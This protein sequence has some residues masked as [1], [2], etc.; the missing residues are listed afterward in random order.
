MK[1]FLS[2]LD[3]L[4]VELEFLSF[5]DVS[6][7]ATGLSGSGVDDGVESLLGELVGDFGVDDSIL[8]SVVYSGN[9]SLGFSLLDLYILGSLPGGEVDSVLV[10]IPLSEGSGVDL[11]DAV[12]DEGLGSDELVVGG[13]VD[14]V[15][16]SGF[17]GDSF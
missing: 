14:D 16:Y 1:S 17:T 10:G 2:G 13:I 9:G 8:L 7:G 15:D 11:D 5:E 4:G 6:V 3:L 12:L